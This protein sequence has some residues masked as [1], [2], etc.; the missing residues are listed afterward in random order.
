MLVL[1]PHANA[2]VV[3]RSVCVCV[4]PDHDLT[5]ESLDQETSFLVHTVGTSL[6]YLGQIRMSRSSG[7][8]QGHRTKN[9]IYKRN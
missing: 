6:E 2:V 3:M 7:Q 5:F 9:G 4:C 1:L 8:G